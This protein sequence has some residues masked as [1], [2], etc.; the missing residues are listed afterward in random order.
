M[1]AETDTLVPTSHAAEMLGE[2]VQHLSEDHDIDFRKETDGSHV[3]EQT[4]FRVAFRVADGGLSVSIRAPNEGALV[5]FKEEVA[6]HVGEVDPKAA[7]A[8]RWSGEAAI[9]GDV[10]P[11][12]RVLRV[13]SSRELFSGMQRVTMH[14]PGLADVVRDGLHLKLMLPSISGRAPIWPR[15]GPNGA[16]IWPTGSDALHARYMTIIAARP[17]V[18]EVD[19]DMVRHGDGLISLWAQSATPGDEIGAMGPAGMQGLPEAERYL[20]A[21]DMTGLSS[22]ARILG[23][24]PDEAEGDVVLSAPEDCEL[25]AYLPKTNLRIHRLAPDIFEAEALPLLARLAK[26]TTPQQAWFAGEFD[27]A[28]AARKLFKSSCGLKKGEQLAVAY[29]RHAHP[30]FMA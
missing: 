30:G 21:A 29:W 5:F 14:M 18:E 23:T 13:R 27:G 19:L 17:E 24:L 10:P 16:P 11:N 8:M 6:K 20:L 7:L 26:R 4:G 2:F 25:S 15:M 9:A 12:F 22:A 1:S 28:Q 3:V